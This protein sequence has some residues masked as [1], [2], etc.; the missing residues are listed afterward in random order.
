MRLVYATVILAAFGAG[1]KKG[2]PPRKDVVTGTVTVDGE[3]REIVGCLVTK[4]AD[5]NELTLLLDNRTKLTKKDGQLERR[6]AGKP[7]ELLECGMV[8]S[9]GRGGSTTNAAWQSGEL[10]MECG[11]VAL[12]VE[13]DCRTSQ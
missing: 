7:A 5:G 4:T 6:D 13:F 11:A 2:E 12:H 10:E 9:G 3:A 8:S 1:C